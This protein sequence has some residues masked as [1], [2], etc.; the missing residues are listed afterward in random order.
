MLNSIKSRF[1]LFSVILIVFSV[2]FP[3]YFL[4]K[5][6]ER[7]FQERS[8]IMLETTLNVVKNGI[9]SM[10]L[11]GQDKD[12]QKML[13]HL[14]ENPNINHI[15]IYDSTGTVH[16]A[17]NP[18]EKGGNIFKIDPNHRQLGETPSFFE[19]IKSAESYVTAQPIQNRPA[20]Q[21]CHGT[22]KKVIAFLD[23]DTDLTQAEE[24]FFTGYR[25][26]LFLA[27]LTIL[28][29]T[30][31][32]YYLFYRFIE[33]P[34]NKFKHAISEVERGNFNS[35]LPPSNYKEL[36]QLGQH[37]NQMLNYLNKSREEIELLHFR[38]LQ[39][40]DKLASLG[41]MAAEMAHEINNPVAICHSR[42]DYLRMEA[43]ENSQLF[44][45][46]D[47]LDVILEQLS[48]V[49][50]ITKNILKYSKKIP[51]NYRQIELVQPVENALMILEPHLKKH[52]ITLIKEFDSV[53]KAG[54]IHIKGDAQQIEQIII[55]LVN[56]AVDSMEKG[57]TIRIKI[58]S[59]SGQTVMLSVS[60]DG[61]GMDEETIS[62]IF[63][64][65]YST[66][67]QDKGTGLGLYIVK[68]ICTEHNA[69]IQCQSIV[70]KGTT[71]SILFKRSPQK[72]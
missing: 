19:Q 26:T 68:K 11:S 18:A 14:S 3:T 31:G 32:F 70:G 54:D 61:Q 6:F 20:C 34:L 69:A 71:F 56:N 55:N 35:H 39:H 64:P 58:A 8:E 2:G 57:G 43:D 72:T 13:G 17:T 50:N 33:N 29:L 28:F 46:G 9:N 59:E 47:D 40:A 21:R 23:I 42:V 25:H 62:K 36:S 53:L 41:E 66:K 5:Q 10:M 51:K 48:R 15:R 67:A 24:F 49:S 22:D 1:I 4:L 52:Q 38:Q 65:F 37:F 45:Y 27:V 44:K 60:D 7:N 16:Y 63:S 30:G 12:I